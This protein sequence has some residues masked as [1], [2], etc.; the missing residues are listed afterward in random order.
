MTA[1]YPPSEQEMLNRLVAGLA[2]LEAAERKI[3]RRLRWRRLKRLARAPGLWLVGCVA[4]ALTW[5]AR[6]GR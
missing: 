6:R 3:T 2:K 5:L 4:W 1:R